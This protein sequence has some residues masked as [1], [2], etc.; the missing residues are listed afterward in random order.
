[1]AQENIN[2]LKGRTLENLILFK[3]KEIE[4]ERSILK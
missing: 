4:L 3:L 2:K 1:M